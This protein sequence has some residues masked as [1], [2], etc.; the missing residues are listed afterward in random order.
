MTRGPTG[1]GLVMGAVLFPVL[2][3]LIVVVVAVVAVKRFGSRT[4]AQSDRLQ[5]EDRPTLRYLVPAGQD[6]AVVLGALRGAGYDASPDS[7]PGP[8][9]PIVIIGAPTGGGPDR[10]HV[11]EVLTQLEQ[12]NVNPDDSAP[13]DLPP[14]RFTDE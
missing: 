5:A 13:L 10:E 4:N 3:A 2:L 11:R 14:V 6:P 12:T 8:S 7:E 9:S 1:H